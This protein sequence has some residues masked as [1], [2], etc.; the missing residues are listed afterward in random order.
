MLVLVLVVLV[1]VLVLLL[2]VLLVLVALVV[3]VVLASREAAGCRRRTAVSNEVVRDVDG[4]PAADEAEGCLGEAAS[5]V[6]EKRVQGAGLSATV[7]EVAGRRC[8]H[9]RCAG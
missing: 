7:D 8:G 2:L 5:R 4:A 3:P 1:L 9:C 6:Y